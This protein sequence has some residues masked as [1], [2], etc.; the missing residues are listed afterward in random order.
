LFTWLLARYQWRAAFLPA[1]VAPAALAAV[2][3]WFAHDAAPAKEHE[4]TVLKPVQMAAPWRALFSNRNLLLLTCAYAS[5]GYFQYIFFYWIYYYFGQVLHLGEAASARYTAILFL[6]EGMVMPLGGLMSDRLA[7][8]YGPQFG[9]RW[10]PIAALGLAAAFTCAGTFSQSLMAVACFSLAFAAAACCE[11]PFW[12]T[13]T[14]LGGEHVGSASSIL[15][16][17]AQVGGFFAPVL[18]PIIAGFFGWSWGLYAGVAIVCLG[19]VA[20]YFIKLWSGDHEPSLESQG[21]LGD[22]RAPTVHSA[23]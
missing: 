3:Y 18:T 2:W 23:S 10:V 12:A 21:G 5:L 13:V 14:E 4:A 16:A 22:E 8:S 7:K 19:A 9:R 11:G 1:A 17:G 15:N 6:A 20:V